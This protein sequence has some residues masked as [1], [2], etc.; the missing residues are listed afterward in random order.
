MTT[1]TEKLLAKLPDAKRNGKGWSAQCPA[2][3]DQDP[4]LS[5]TEGDDGRVLVHCHGG[6][7]VEAVCNAL[8]LKLAD[9]MPDDTS[10]G[11]TPTE[12]RQARKKRQYRRRSQSKTYET[13]KAAVAALERQHGE[14]SALWTYHDANGD[15]VGVIVRWDKAGGK[16]IRPVARRGDGWAVGGMP[17]PRPLY[18]LPNLAGAVRVYITEGEKAADAARAIGLT[19]TTS[20]HG[21]Q[22]PDKT[23]WTPLA[24]TECVILPDNDDPGGKYADAVGAILTKLTPP[25]MVKVVKLPDLP[26]HGDIADWVEA[27]DAVESE[28]LRERV[29]A[30]AGEAEP[31]RNRATSRERGRARIECRPIP[32]S[33]LGDGE[34]VDWIWHGYIARAF[35]TLLIGLWKA[36]K[37]TLLAHLIKAMQ[38][39]GDIAGPVLAAKVLVITEEGSGLWARR[40]DDVGFGDHAHFEIRPFKCRPTLPEWMLYI[41]SVAAAVERSKYDLVIIDTWASVNPCPDENDAAGMM[42]AL[43]PL[44]GIVDAGAAVLLAHHPR[45]G[46]ATEGQAS[47]G[48]GALPGFVDTI[49]EL[50]R[51]N[52]HEAHDRRRK[53]RGY[54]RFEETQSEVVIELTDADYKLVGTT[55]DAHRDDRQRVIGEILTDSEWRT[56]DDVREQWP[57]RTV[58]RPAKRTLQMDLNHGVDAGRWHRDGKGAKG[59]PYKYKFDSRSPQPLSTQNESETQPTD[60]YREP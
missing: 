18:C 43:S 29:E 6:C 58:P 54:G 1:P 60:G 27:H 44:H 50:R 46:D 8:G 34:Q 22:S 9:L 40:R 12:P 56:V 7:R 33:Q 5:V 26:E 32:A 45:K 14:R 47:R 59:D 55:G 16:D 19:A 36:G 2:H 3:N 24:G 15:P 4:S 23:D 11:S 35:I 28:A 30:L 51:F 41:D 10:T 39:G 13:A 48:S 25:A 20:A 42:A 17:E 57:D 49:I 52:A 37:S 31:I 21:S 53:L 38:T